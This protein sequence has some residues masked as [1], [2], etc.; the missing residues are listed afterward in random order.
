MKEKEELLKEL[1]DKKVIIYN[2]HQSI[3]NMEKYTNGIRKI[4]YNLMHNFYK[5]YN[6]VVDKCN[7]YM[8]LFYITFILL[9]ISILIIIFI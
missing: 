7:T 5:R 8:V 2:L 6:R 1:E 3:S 4:N 9:I